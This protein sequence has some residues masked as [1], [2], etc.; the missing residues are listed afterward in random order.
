MGVVL[1]GVTPYLVVRMAGYRAVC[2]LI[3]SRTSPTRQAVTLSANLNGF[4][5]VPAATLRHNMG[6]EKGSGA[7]VSGRFGLCTSRD[8]RMNALA[9]SASKTDRWMVACCA[10]MLW[11]IGVLGNLCKTLQNPDDGGY[12]KAVK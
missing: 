2:A 7:G 10:G 11:A 12:L 4:G 6:A 3:Q 9:G 1:P 8:L 5:N